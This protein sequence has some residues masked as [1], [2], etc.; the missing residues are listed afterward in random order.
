MSN[1]RSKLGLTLIE[2]MIALMVF[3]MG[4]LAVATMQSHG[5]R[6]TASARQ[7][8]CDTAAVVR[9]L[10]LLLVLGYD[11]PLLVDGDMGFS[12][13]RPDH[14]PVV[15]AESGSTL[16]WE[17]ADDEPVTGSKHIQVSVGRSVS[18]RSAG[19]LSFHC[20]KVGELPVLGD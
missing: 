9:Q 1:D 15:V 10:E 12:P 11:H 2:V 14:G 17:V 4:I 18:G 7:R 13:D 5:M 20:L 6:C 19:G 8:L 16:E 3:S